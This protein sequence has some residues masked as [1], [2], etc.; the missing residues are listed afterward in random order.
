[1]TVWTR[2]NEI[3]QKDDIYMYFNHCMFRNT[4]T[5]KI[6]FALSLHKNIRLIAKLLTNPIETGNCC[7]NVHNI[8]F[9]VNYPLI[10]ISSEASA[11]VILANIEDMF[12]LYYTHSFI[13]HK[14]LRLSLC[15]HTGLCE[16]IEKELHWSALLIT[17]VNHSFVGSSRSWNTVD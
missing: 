7:D 16:H 11:S 15:I 17:R 10:T 5:T 13:P 4:S 1:M 2:I 12:P 6:Y 3:L 9:F 14:L 8:V